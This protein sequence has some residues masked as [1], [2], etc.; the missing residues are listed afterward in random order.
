MFRIHP[1]NLDNLCPQGRS[2][3]YATGC[4]E[5][6]NAVVSTW[7]FWCSLKSRSMLNGVASLSRYGPCPLDL[8][9]NSKYS[10]ETFSWCFC[11]T[12]K[13]LFAAHLKE[14]LNTAVIAVW[15]VFRKS[16]Q[17]T[18]ELP[19]LGSGP[20]EVSYFSLF[21]YKCRSHCLV[22][23][24]QGGFFCC[25]WFCFVFYLLKV[26]IKQVPSKW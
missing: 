4:F 6:K 25:F 26:W 5:S 3:Q 16:W 12:M 15:N 9:C 22:F 7:A 10:L 23:E 17:R 2:W 1:D 20:C 8:Q 18:Y 24:M 13:I 11:R 14:T 19:L 21:S